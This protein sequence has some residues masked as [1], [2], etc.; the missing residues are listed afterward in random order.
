MS[1]GKRASAGKQT[2]LASRRDSLAILS[3]GWAAEHNRQLTREI[4][5]IRNRKSQ[6]FTENHAESRPSR[7]QKL[8]QLRVIKKVVFTFENALKTV[9]IS[10][11]YCARVTRPSNVSKQHKHAFLEIIFL[12]SLRVFFEKIAKIALH[13]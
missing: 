11:D 7:E 2:L 4:R 12:K 6:Q 1:L 13:N 5:L 9:P 10:L 8:H 3:M